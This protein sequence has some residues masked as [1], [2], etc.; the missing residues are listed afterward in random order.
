MVFA[1]ILKKSPLLRLRFLGLLADPELM[2]MQWG[3]RIAI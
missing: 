2:K 1:F 3:I